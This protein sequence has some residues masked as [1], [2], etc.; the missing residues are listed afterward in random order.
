MNK[1]INYL[2]KSFPVGLCDS[3]LKYGL[4]IVLFYFILSDIHYGKT[5]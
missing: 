2:P 1:M 4:A 3:S 5:G